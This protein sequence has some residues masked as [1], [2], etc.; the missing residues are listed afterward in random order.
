MLKTNVEFGRP[1]NIDAERQFKR[2]FAENST[3]IELECQTLHLLYYE[4]FN[5]KDVSCVATDQLRQLFAYAS[6][7]RFWT[8][9][10]NGDSK[11]SW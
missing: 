1:K 5:G 3:R 8:V 10:H 2:H 9:L 6:S 11:A 4:H 7:E